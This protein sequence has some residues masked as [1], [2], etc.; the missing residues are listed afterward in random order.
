MAEEGWTVTWSRASEELLTKWK[1]FLDHTKNSNTPG[2]PQPPL[3]KILC[4]AIMSEDYDLIRACISHGAKLDG[5]VY[6]AA[7]RALTLELLQILIPAGFD[8]NYKEDRYCCEDFADH[9]VIS[10]NL[11]E[12]KY[13][14]HGADPNINP[15][16]DLYPA[17]NLAVQNNNAE[18]VEL[19]IQYGAKIMECLFRHGADVNND[20]KDRIKE[21]VKYIKGVTTLH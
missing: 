3:E 11:E 2:E 15:I 19:L 4:G 6:V 21:Y 7:R 14:E 1:L 12:T 18:I 10:G 16:A 8:V 20:A 17:L 9:S 13:L 5:W